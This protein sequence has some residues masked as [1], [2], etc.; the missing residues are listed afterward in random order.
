MKEGFEKDL[1]IMNRNLEVKKIVYLDGGLA[2][3]MSGYAFSL[4]LRIQGVEPEIDFIWFKRFGREKY[5]LKSVF[6]IEVKE[7]KSH[8]CYDIYNSGNPLFVAMRKCNLLRLLIM[9]KLVPKLYYTI[10]PPYGG[11][12]FD[13]NN[14]EELLENDKEAYFWG[15]WG[16]SDYIESHAADMRKVFMFPK[17]T[18]IR[19][20]E[21][22][23]NISKTNSVSLHIRRGDYLKYTD[24]F[25]SVSLDYYSK[26]V[27]LI[28]EKIDNPHFYIFSDDIQW[29]KLNLYNIGINE[30]NSTIVDW[31]NGDNSYIDMQLMSLCK[32]NIVTNSGFSMWAGFL[33]GNENKIVIAPEKYFTEEWINKNGKD[34]YRLP[35]SNWITLLN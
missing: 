25:A 22:V 6:N 5:L 35:E 24:V 3:Q 4:F 31:N 15:Y 12:N 11:N 9:L 17:V 13:I 23:E 18:D 27:K 34:L 14:V 2:S 21:A 28:T 20:I 33:N 32:N 10:K 16:F 29:S 26:A 30:Y 19:N 7:F 1:L 8:F